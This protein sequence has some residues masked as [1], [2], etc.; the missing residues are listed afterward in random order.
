MKID[1]N[2]LINRL[3]PSFYKILLSL[4]RRLLG[5]KYGVPDLLDKLHVPQPLITRIMARR[6]VE[7][8]VKPKSHERK[9]SEFLL[10]Q[11][12]RLFVD[13]GAWLGYYS[14]LL[15]N[16]F[17]EILA[18]EPDP[19]NCRVLNEA[20]HI[21]KLHKIQVLPLAAS[22]RTGLVRLYVSRQP[23]IYGESSLSSLLKSRRRWNDSFKILKGGFI[24]V[25]ATTL[26][27]LLNP[28]DFVDLVKVDVEGAEWMVLEG[29]RN[30]MHKI[31]SWVI[32]LHDLTKKIELQ[33]MMKDYGY[34]SVWLDSL[35][36][37]CVR[38]AQV[39]S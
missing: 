11:H 36:I 34:N 39:K 26:D 23:T 12:G 10:Q 37:F 38:E 17:D 35:H 20:K 15:Y 3:F 1:E 19:R 7:L 25:K 16:N 31:N 30:V 28:Y 14:L 29:A 9:I 22:N 32:E 6:V 13:I 27:N 2:V 18:L 5:P 24:H 8:M 21:Y 33:N 4:S